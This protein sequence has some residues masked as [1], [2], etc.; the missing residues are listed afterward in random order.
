VVRAWVRPPASRRAASVA[1]ALAVALL[2]TSCTALAPEPAP[3]P[4]APAPT[5]GGVGTGAVARDV[6]YADGAAGPRWAPP[7]YDLSLPSAGPAPLVVILHERGFDQRSVAYP[8]IAQRLSA[9]GVAVASVRWGLQAPPNAFLTAGGQRQDL[10]RAL[11]QQNGALDCA[12]PAVVQRAADAGITVDRIVLLGHGAGAN[13]AATAALGGPRQVWPGCVTG[14]ADWAADALVLWDGDWLLA[15]RW[16]GWGADLGTQV[17]PLLTPWAWAGGPDRPRVD[18]VAT[19]QVRTGSAFRIC[20]RDQPQFLA[21]RDP[22]GI[23][24]PPLEAVEALADGC[25]TR[26]EAGDALAAVLA[27]AGHLTSSIDLDSPRTRHSVLARP[28]LD[29]LVALLV[30]RSQ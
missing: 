21:D 14:P 11:H 9:V 7:V 25:L 30:E 2:L 12:V 4:P 5:L 16:D 3:S 6:P 26:G 18:L 20:L 22:T 17:M 27:E 19:G 29:A 28:D 10:L 23:I 1:V 24:G 8:L 15:Q 13:L